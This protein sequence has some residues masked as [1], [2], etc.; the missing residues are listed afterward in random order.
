MTLHPR[1]RVS[2][3]E[4]RFRRD[5]VIEVSHRLPEEQNAVLE[6]ALAQVRS[7]HQAVHKATAS[8]TESIAFQS[9]SGC[10]SAQ[11]ELAAVIQFATEAMDLLRCSVSEEKVE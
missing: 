3:L 4:N 6:E 7:S 1:H 8:I 11:R 5:V 2:E 9:S 10:S